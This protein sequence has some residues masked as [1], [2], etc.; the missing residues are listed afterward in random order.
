[1]QRFIILMSQKVLILNLKV[2]EYFS[3]FYCKENINNINTIN[4]AKDFINNS[5][6]KARIDVVKK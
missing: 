3:I 6:K 1:M 2:N 4:D 5:F